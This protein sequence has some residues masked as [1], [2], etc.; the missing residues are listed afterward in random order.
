[1]ATIRLS[2]NWKI[3]IP[4]SIRNQLCLKAGDQVDLCVEDDGSLR[5]V[6]KTL[7]ASQVLGI[8]SDKSKKALA[9]KEMDKEIH[10]AFRQ[11]RLR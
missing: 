11:G 7:K 2:S 3:T 8:L 1:M 9:P 4:K 5:I 10:K 6:P